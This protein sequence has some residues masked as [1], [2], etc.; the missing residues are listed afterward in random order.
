MRTVAFIAAA[1][2]ILTVTATAGAVTISSTALVTLTVGQYD[3]SSWGGGIVTFTGIDLEDLT[4]GELILKFGGASGYNTFPI[5]L[6]Q[7]VGVGKQ[8]DLAQAFD[9]KF[10]GGT[11]S[12]HTFNTNAVT[13]PFD[14][15]A[16]LVPDPYDGAW[17]ITP[18][19]RIPTGSADDMP[20]DG[21]IGDLDV[22]HTFSGGTYTSEYAFYLTDL[23]A[24]AQL[25]TAASGFAEIAGASVAVIPEPLTMLA[26]F[27]GI[28]GL[29]G[30]IRRRKLA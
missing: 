22:W 6:R 9:H 25:D 20:V 15:R 11:K 16:I 12:S 10:D 23:E 3:V 24:F 19:Y 1:G 7:D 17:I 8:I 4:T 27:T 2:L 14:I 13:G 30:Y 18:Q 28:A 21:S 26:V 29:A 5:S